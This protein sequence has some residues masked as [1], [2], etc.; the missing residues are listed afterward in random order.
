MCSSAQ[1]PAVIDD[2]LLTVRDGQ[3]DVLQMA[4]LSRPTDSWLGQI[5]GQTW[6]STCTL[7]ARPCLPDSQMLILPFVVRSERTGEQVDSP[8][9]PVRKPHLAISR[10]VMLNRRLVVFANA[11]PLLPQAVPPDSQLLPLSRSASILLYS[12]RK[13]MTRCQHNSHGPEKFSCCTNNPRAD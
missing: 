6:R 9:C 13:Q 1:M 11:S 12:A 2:L 10:S 4:H 8:A 7:S 5:R 3:N